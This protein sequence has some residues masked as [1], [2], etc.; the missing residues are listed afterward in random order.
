MANNGKEAPTAMAAMLPLSRNFHSGEFKPKIRRIETGRT[1][2]S[3]SA[4]VTQP[5]LIWYSIQFGNY[6]FLLS[7]S[8]SSLTLL[9]SSEFSAAA[10][11]FTCSKWKRGWSNSERI[12]KLPIKL[13]SS[14][15]KIYFCWLFS[16][17]W[18]D[19]S[20]NL[21]W[22]AT[23]HECQ[24]PQ[25]RLCRC[26]LCGRNWRCWTIDATPQLWCDPCTLC[27]RHSGPTFPN[28][29]PE[30]TLLRPATIYLADV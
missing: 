21:F 17:K 3:L 6:L 20:R 11:S 27:P 16:W 25:W 24:I 7:C 13:V 9:S 15:A 28:S 14:K 30:P 8:S 1:A 22:P 18:R 2:S 4:T 5:F 19:C 12:M 10:S 29:D 23:Q 26:K